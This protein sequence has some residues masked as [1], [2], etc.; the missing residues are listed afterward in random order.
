VKDHVYTREWFDAH[1]SLRDEYRA[2][3]D[4]LY[5]I[6]EPLTAV[7]LGCGVGLILE[8][9]VELHVSAYGFDGSSH[10]REAAPASVRH[11]IDRLDLTQPTPYRRNDNFVQYDLVICT[12]VAEH[13]EAEHASSLVAHVVQR[14]VRPGFIFFTAATPGQGGTDH[15]NE[16]P[17]EYW[18]ERFAAC[19]RKLDRMRTT[20]ARKQLEERC[21]GMHWFGKNAM[22]FR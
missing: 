1:Y 8:R 4:L 3:A 22:V 14:C 9:L 10:A 16:Q 12:E 18:I 11:L 5:E 21:R 17:H 20:Y 15:V 2:V 13:L 7:D 19:G 6:F